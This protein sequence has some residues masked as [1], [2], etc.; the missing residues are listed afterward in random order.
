MEQLNESQFQEVVFMLLFQSTKMPQGE[1][2]EPI[3]HTSLPYLASEG[4]RPLKT[5]EFWFLIWIGDYFV[6][7]GVI[8][9]SFTEEISKVRAWGS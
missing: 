3:S 2:P 8:S 5:V 6:E 4:I 9:T 7:N 1:T